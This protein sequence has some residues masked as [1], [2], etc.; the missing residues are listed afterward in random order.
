MRIEM[1]S[2]LQELLRHGSSRLWTAARCGR[3]GTCRTHPP[4]ILITNYSMLNIMLM[5]SVEALIFDQTKQ[6]LQQDPIEHLPS[7]RRRA[8]HL[9]RDSWH[10]SRVP[11][12]RLLDR[13]GL[14]AGLQSAS[15][16]CFQ[17][18]GREWRRGPAST[19]SR[20]SGA[21]R[22]AFGSSV[23]RRSRSTPER[24]PPCARTWQRCDNCE[25]TCARH[26]HSLAPQRR[27]S[28]MQQVRPAAPAGAGPELD[29]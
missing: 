9:S 28:R 14:P 4:D 10:R 17:R 27:R 21:I 20:S 6:W 25:T 5:R 11:H 16:H 7:R 19:S 2:S 24:S 26:L 13:I 8:A 15:H 29:T 18:I 3:A 1:P 12:P 22:I 23:P